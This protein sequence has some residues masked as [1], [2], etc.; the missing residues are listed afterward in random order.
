MNGLDAMKDPLT[1]K[2]WIIEGCSFKSLETAVRLDANVMRVALRRNTFVRPGKTA[3]E[4]L[5]SEIT[6]DENIFE[7]C[8][9][10]PWGTATDR[11]KA[12]RNTVR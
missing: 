11:V 8:G 9:P 2:D 1:N 3:L 7:G 5:G 12:D 6:V 10:T 4:L